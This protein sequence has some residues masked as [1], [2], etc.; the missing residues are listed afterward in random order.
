MTASPRA[1]AQGAQGLDPLLGQHRRGAP[2]SPA[3]RIVSRRVTRSASSPGTTAAA[4]GQVGDG[5]ERRGWRS[6]GR[7]AAPRRGCPGWPGRRRPCAAASS[8]RCRRCRRRAGRPRPPGRRWRRAGPGSRGRRTR[9]STAMRPGS[10]VSEPGGDPVEH[11]AEPARPRPAAR[12]TGAGP[13]AGAAAG[14]RSAHACDQH[15]EVGLRLGSRAGRAARPGPGAPARRARC[16]CGQLGGAVAVTAATSPVAGPATAGRQWPNPK[17]RTL[18]ARICC[19]AVS[20]APDQAHWKATSA[21][22]RCGRRPGPAA[23]PGCRRRRGCR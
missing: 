5:V 12:P 21:W 13:A 15:L 4:V 9:P 11:G 20:G 7:T 19:S 1:G 22:G 18:T 17:R 3:P 2:R 10:S 16:R 14:R 23:A 6:R 8:C